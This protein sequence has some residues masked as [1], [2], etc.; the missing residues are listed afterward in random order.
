MQVSGQFHAT[1]ML[2]QGENPMYPL[3]RGLGWSQIQ[4]EHF[5]EGKNLL[6]ARIKPWIIQPIS[7]SLYWLRYSS[8]P[9]LTFATAVY[10]V[11]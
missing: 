4:S 10:E 1:A 6:P 5:G 8:N 7:K 11:T 2:D 3:N 9:V